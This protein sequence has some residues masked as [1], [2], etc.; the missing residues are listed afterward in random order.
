MNLP[1]VSLK[2]DVST[3]Y[4]SSFMFQSIIHNEELIIT[5]LALLIPDIQSHSLDFTNV[6][7]ICSILQSFKE[8]T[9]KVGSKT[10]SKIIL[11]Y[12]KP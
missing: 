6:H 5:S 9:N 2:Q 3:K 12:L 8:I 1:E 7:K 11:F 10:I 4:N